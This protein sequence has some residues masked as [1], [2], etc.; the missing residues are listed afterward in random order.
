MEC[1]IMDFV[2]KPVLNQ[3]N[4]NALKYEKD[5]KRRNRTIGTYA[6]FA[7]VFLMIVIYSFLIAYG[8]GYLGMTDAIPGYSLLSAQHHR[9][10][11]HIYE[12]EWFLL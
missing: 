8:Y 4:L 6:A 2:E 3:S 1:K 5:K 9:A 7:V 12:D 11:L 10:V